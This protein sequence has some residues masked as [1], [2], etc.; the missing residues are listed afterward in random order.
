MKDLKEDLAEALISHLEPLQTAI[1][2]YLA[3]PV[4]LEKIVSEGS[5]KANAIARE[6]I[7]IVKNKMGLG[8][9]M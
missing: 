6:K 9:Q 1:K 2:G 7:K 5:Q 3:D 8:L 4:E